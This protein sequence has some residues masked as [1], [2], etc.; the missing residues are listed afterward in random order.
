MDAFK[1]Y[2][3]SINKNLSTHDAGEGSH[4]AAL[5]TLVES[6]DKKVSAQIL[7][8]HI[9]E[10]APD[11]KI[12]RGNTI[13]IGYI[14]AKN[15]GVD[16]DTIEKSD[17]LKRYLTLP[18][19]ILTDFLEFRL[20]VDGKFI[21]NSCIATINNGKIKSDANGI[22]ETALLLGEFLSFHGKLPDTAKELA[23]HMA[24]L[25]HFIRVEIV[26]VLTSTSQ[27]DS[28][29][30]QLSAF[31]ESLIPDLDEAKFADMYA[32]TIT[33]GLFAGRCSDPSSTSFSRFQA[34]ELIPKTNPFLR[35]TFQHIAVDLDERVAF[36]VDE[37]V[38]LLLCSDMESILKDFGK[39]TARK[40]PVVHFYE[41]FLAEYDPKLRKS[42]G[43]YYTP[44]P[45]VS[46]IVRSIDY[47]LK[48]H[49]GKP[50]GFADKSVLILDPAVGTATF[51][52]MVIQEI[53]EMQEKS[54]QQGYW[55]S[56]VAQN[57]LKRIF[58]FELLMA[59]YTVAHLKLG[60]LLKETG[61]KFQTD[62][63]LG[64]YLTD[65][66]EES[67]KKSEKLAGFNQYIVEEANAAAEI[68]KEK[69][70]MVVLGNPPYSKN[71]ANKGKW[72]TQLIN[73]VFNKDGNEIIKGYK[74]IDGEPLREKNPKWLQDDYVKFIRFGQWRIEGTKQ[75][76]LG[77][78]TNHGYLDNP[79]FRGMRQSLINSFTDIYIFNLHGNSKKKEIAPDGSKDENIFDIQQGV[80]IS[81]FIKEPSKAS[82]AIVYYADL[83]GKREGKY[84][85][86]VETDIN[87]SD[88]EKLQPHSPS[89]LFVPKNES[90]L[91]E[92]D[93]CWS[94]IKIFKVF[95]STVTTARNDF[96]MAYTPSALTMRIDD[97]RNELTDDQSLREK[98]Q[99][100]DV[101]YWNLKTSREKLQKIKNVA[102]FI[103]PYCYRPFDFR[104]VY[105]HPAVCERLR[106]E[107]MQHMGKSNIAFLTHRPQSPK[108][109]TH[110][111][112]T[113][114]IG[115]Q[116][117]AANKTEGGGNSFQFPLYLYPTEGKMQLDDSYRHPNLNPEFIKALSEKLGLTFIEDGKGDS[118]QTFGPENIFD[119]AYAIFQSPTYRTRY[120]E[121]LKTDFPRLPLTSDKALFKALVDKGA[122]L[123]ALHL[124]EAP[125]LE[126]K[127]NQI[128][129][130][131]KGSH[132][133]E[134]VTYVEKAQRVYINKEQYFEGIEPSVWNFQIGGYQICEKW[135]KDRKGRLLSQNDINH[136]QKIVIA[137]RETIQLMAEIDA[138]I[139]EWPLK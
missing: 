107:V 124:M 103:K 37:L 36:W 118:K 21:K 63:R 73:G 92:Y 75:G 138:L 116:C 22:Q 132:I 85:A 50:Q 19:L 114:M 120:A 98:Y 81:F 80:A 82:P 78:I 56:Y 35:K 67:F 64:V 5:K 89:Y 95:A 14:E 79:T 97:L 18:N 16:L 125:V 101:S 6:L 46:Y 112:C 96:T 48:T 71:S 54:G 30:S 62:E 105:Y 134:K 60:L 131:V 39:G 8:S 27:N 127:F 106:P 20:Y 76:I 111:Y 99:L 93:N 66:L 135:L 123:V 65:T 61:Y 34:S 104:F 25:A 109:F 29:L 45:V 4:Y 126:A 133:V 129:Y 128:G 41:T 86:L 84:Q 57:L 51:L 117:V 69:P 70:I 24:R 15:I 2:L 10:G 23:R 52:Y 136:Y 91:D 137:L 108:D 1:N 28:L 44:E 88:W 77:L 49:F 31:R 68:K 42:R 72:I 26:N 13:T 17:Q 47:L 53:F 139:P 32:Q 9:K 3:D 59:P 115:D 102:S 87:R 7:P 130:P 83:W 100:K 94:V 90:R 110:A 55:D 38:E 40:D 74:T 11:L 122:Q 113:N 33:Y 121:F 119:Y 12:S 43:I 58:G